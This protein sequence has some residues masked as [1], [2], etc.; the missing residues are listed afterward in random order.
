MRAAAKVNARETWAGPDLMAVEKDVN[1]FDFDV[2]AQQNRHAVPARDGVPVTAADAERWP[3]ASAL[4][5]HRRATD[6]VIRE[7]HISHP[8]GIVDI[9][10]VEYDRMFHPPLDLVEL[11]MDKLFP[12][13][14]HGKGVRSVQ[15]FIAL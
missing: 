7:A 8:E 2:T 14:D 12:L 15:G 9:P 10:P 4:G 11:R 5:S 13:G 6:A 3:V 1:D